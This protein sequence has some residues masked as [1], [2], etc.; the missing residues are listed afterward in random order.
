[1]LLTRLTKAAEPLLRRDLPGRKILLS[2][3]L[4]VLPALFTSNALADCGSIH[5]TDTQICMHVVCLTDGTCNWRYAHG[6]GKVDY[7]QANDG[8]TVSLCA[9]E[10]STVYVT[11]MDSSGEDE[12]NTKIKCGDAK[13]SKTFTMPNN[14]S[15]TVS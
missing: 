2:F 3:S 5:C 10:G 12:G 11:T 13:H 8:S 9:N 7:L 1:M 14:N 4:S 15:C 6:T